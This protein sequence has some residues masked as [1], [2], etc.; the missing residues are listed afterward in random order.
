MI[1]IFEAMFDGQ[2]KEGSPLSF[3][4]YVMREIPYVIDN[5]V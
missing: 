4:M 5:L 2:E 3:Y 1:A